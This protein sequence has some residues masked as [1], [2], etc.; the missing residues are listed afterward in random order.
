ML[1]TVSH[2]ETGYACILHPQ[3]QI[4]LHLGMQ[5][6]RGRDVYGVT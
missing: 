5:N 3:M 6:T 2:R 4:G 1:R